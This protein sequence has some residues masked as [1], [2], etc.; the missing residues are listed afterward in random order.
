MTLTSFDLTFLRA[1][2]SAPCCSSSKAHETCPPAAAN[3]SGVVESWKIHVEKK[4]CSELCG[5]KCVVSG[6]SC[7]FG[8]AAIR[9]LLEQVVSFRLLDTF[10]I[11]SSTFEAFHSKHMW[12]SE[13]R[14]MHKFRR[15]QHS[16]KKNSQNRHNVERKCNV[17]IMEP[18]GED[19]S[20]GK[21]GGGIVACYTLDEDHAPS[22]ANS[23]NTTV[24]RSK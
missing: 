6:K 18:V 21:R 14:A 22:V 23:V 2:V 10:H 20:R 4:F 12:M 3:I 24:N 9:I 19:F 11:S 17:T 5:E 15:Y 8:T 7:Q 16:V 1:F 13:A